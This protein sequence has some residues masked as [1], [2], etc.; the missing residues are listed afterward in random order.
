MPPLVEVLQWCRRAPTTSPVAAPEPKLKWLHIRSESYESKHCAAADGCS[1]TRGG[2]LLCFAL[3]CF[4]VGVYWHASVSLY[5]PF[6]LSRAV[7]PS[8]FA[9]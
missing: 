2:G 4:P 5:I 7:S 3:L 8:A 6:M 1:N 9:R